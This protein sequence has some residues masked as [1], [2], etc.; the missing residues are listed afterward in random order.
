M[1]Q[2]IPFGHLTPLEP[3]LCETLDKLD[4]EAEESAGLR[5]TPGK[6]TA[7]DV[8][9]MEQLHPGITALVEKSVSYANAGLRAALSSMTP[10]VTSGVKVCK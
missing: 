7:A 3:S 5:P 9:S 10:G 2:A 8:D 4:R 1:T 6:F